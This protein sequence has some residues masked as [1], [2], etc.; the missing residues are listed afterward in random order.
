MIIGVFKNMKKKEL[1]KVG[2]DP[3]PNSM[4]SYLLLKRFYQKQDHAYKAANISF[5][6]WLTFRNRLL[7][8]IQKA[9]KGKLICHYCQNDLIAN[10]NIPHVKKSRK[11]TLDHVRPLAK[12]GHRFD[13]NNLVV[14]CSKCNG[15]KGDKMNFAAKKGKK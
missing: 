14:A 1:H 15:E 8:R 4:A 13:A 9:N 10:F 7:R 12:G 2:E 11:A 5:R 3:H 6:V